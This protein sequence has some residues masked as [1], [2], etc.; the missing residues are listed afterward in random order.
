[1]DIDPEETKRRTMM[2]CYDSNY[3]MDDAVLFACENS[4]AGKICLLSPAASSYDH[5]KNFEERGAD[6][7]ECVRKLK[8]A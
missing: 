4:E 7:K 8:N 1:M 5:Y 3:S 6:F 2:C